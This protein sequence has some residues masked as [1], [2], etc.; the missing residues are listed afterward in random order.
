VSRSGYYAHLNKYERPRRLRD[1]ELKPLIRQAFE[2][3]R[4][5]YGSPRIKLELVLYCNKNRN[6]MQI[7]S[8][9]RESTP[10]VLSGEDR[11]VLAARVRS[12]TCQKRDV[13]RA[14]IVLMAAEGRTNLEIATSLGTRVATA[15][16]WRTRFAREGFAG[17]CD[18]PR[19]GKAP[20]Y[21]ERTES[22]VLEKLDEPA[23]KGWAKW[24][25]RLL[26]EALGDVSAHQVWR[27]LRKRGIS[28][29]KRRSWC[30]STRSRVCEKSR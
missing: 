24:N 30:I 11:A 18:K 4:G 20:L 6:S 27:I 17:L 9:S 21:D 16:Q 26:A 12:Q 5:V 7:H 23:P 19:P 3:G 8:M 14:R 22:R 29:E 15:S 13:F 2:R 10:I 28:L 25:G 1:E